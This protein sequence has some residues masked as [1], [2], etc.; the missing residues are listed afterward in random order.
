MPETV[1]VDADDVR[2]VAEVF[3]VAAT[4]F[5][6]SLQHI[7]HFGDALEACARMGQAAVQSQ[8]PDDPVPGPAQIA[9]IHHE[10][11]LAYQNAG[12]DNEQAFA[13]VLTYI[14]ANAS[15]SAIRHLNGG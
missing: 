6:S 8:M 9:V 1:T 3:S 14:S 11:L 10:M 4:A 7:P 2:C 5:G 15:A 13:I 12:F